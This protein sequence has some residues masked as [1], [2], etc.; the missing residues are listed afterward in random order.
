MSSRYRRYAQHIPKYLVDRP[1]EIVTHCLKKIDIANSADLTEIVMTDHVLF[2][3]LSHKCGYK[4]KYTT[5]F[6]DKTICRTVLAGIGNFLL[7]PPKISSL[8]MECSSPII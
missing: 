5:N 3:T 4:K 8:V 2:S 1:G 6:A 7:T